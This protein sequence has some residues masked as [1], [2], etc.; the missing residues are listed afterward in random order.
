MH[1]EPNP[2]NRSLTTEEAPCKDSGNTSILQRLAER[3]RTA[4][5]DGDLRAVLPL[6]VVAAGT[7]AYEMAA[8]RRGNQQ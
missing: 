7:L 1:I 5:P 6:V 3:Y 2:A 8:E 4:V